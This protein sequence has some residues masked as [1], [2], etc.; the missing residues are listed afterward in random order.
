MKSSVGEKYLAF[1]L[2]TDEETAT[3]RFIERFGTP[4][5]YIFEDGIL[6]LLG[7]VPNGEGIVIHNKTED[8]SEA[9]QLK[10]F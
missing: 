4:P 3:Q 8:L 1:T 7:P 5:E 6:L 9:E 10:M 2:D